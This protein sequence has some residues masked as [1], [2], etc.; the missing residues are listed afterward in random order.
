M[1]VQR[2]D[3][4]Q[5]GDLEKAKYGSLVTYSDYLKLE[6]KYDSLQCKQPAETKWYMITYTQL[7][8]R[9]VTNPLANEYFREQLNKLLNDGSCRDVKV[10]AVKPVQFETETITKINVT[11]IKD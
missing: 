5:D 4:D 9:T 7:G 6:A 3:V 2:Y 10:F 11:K 8:V 1:T